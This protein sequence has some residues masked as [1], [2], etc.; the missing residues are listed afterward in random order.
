[1]RG[2]QYESRGR[3]GLG[4]SLEYVNHLTNRGGI[5][6]YAGYDYFKN[7]LLKNI[8][9]YTLRDTLARFP[10]AILDVS[11]I[12]VRIGYQQHLFK[13]ASFVYAE[14]G[15]AKYTTKHSGYKMNDNYFTYA[16]GAG[17]RFSFREQRYVQL[18]FNYNYYGTGEYIKH[19]YLNLRVAI[20]LAF[21]KRR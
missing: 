9:E 4:G 20:G 7:K 13:G 16:L 11:F 15:I 3:F 17:H 19:N 12:P 10:A 18:S 5:R 8:D 1:L 21:D 6:L 14:G 2:E